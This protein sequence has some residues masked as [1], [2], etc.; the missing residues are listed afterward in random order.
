MGMGFMLL[1]ERETARFLHGGWDEGF[2]T[3]AVAYRNSGVGAVIMVNSNEGFEMMDEILYA[4][5]FEYKW[6]GY[7]S[8]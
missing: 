4:I 2:V 5:A 6:P 8:K 1:G 7:V 3:M